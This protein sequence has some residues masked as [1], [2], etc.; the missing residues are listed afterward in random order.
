MVPENGKVKPMIKKMIATTL[1]LMGAGLC[2]WN[3][4]TLLQD[5]DLF[6][7]WLSSNPMIIYLLGTFILT[8]ALLFWRSQRNVT[9]EI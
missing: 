1:L 5:S 6:F 7:Q 9:L 3:K 8:F 4:S 2:I